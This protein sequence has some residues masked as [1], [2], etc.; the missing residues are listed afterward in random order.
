M[1]VIRV[2]NN[3]MS[4][5]CIIATPCGNRLAKLATKGERVDI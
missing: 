1:Y 4:L 3:S 2:D 5:L